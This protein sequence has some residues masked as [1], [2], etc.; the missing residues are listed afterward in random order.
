MRDVCAGS[1]LCLDPYFCR[2]PRAWLPKPCSS[3]LKCPQTSEAPDRCVLN[4]NPHHPHPTCSPQPMGQ[5]FPERSSST[6]MFILIYSLC[7]S[8]ENTTSVGA[9]SCLC[10]P[11]LHLQKSSRHLVCP[12]RSGVEL[13]NK[14]GARGKGGTNP[15]TAPSP[16]GEVT[17]G[18]KSGD[19]G[20]S[21][22]VLAGICSFLPCCAGPGGCWQGRGR[23][24]GA[25]EDLRGGGCW[26]HR[27]LNLEGGVT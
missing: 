24:W 11:L 2:C 26:Q 19:P 25:C 22:M 9:G 4:S 16:G 7:D 23:T 17:Q 21:P 13:V 14:R 5:V 6:G 15:S 3:S 8:P 12:S 27:H 20:A 10:G 18:S 1:S